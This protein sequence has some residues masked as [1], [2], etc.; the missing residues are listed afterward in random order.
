MAP[1]KNRY[2][3]P[4]VMPGVDTT[5]YFQNVKNTG[6][7]CTP[8]AYTGSYDYGNSFYSFEMGLAHVMVLNSYTNTSFGSAQYTWLED[9]LASVDTKVTPWIIAMFHSPWY[10]SNEV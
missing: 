6:F 10:N 7:D 2:K 8:S 4:E 1:Y 5:Q 9:D 3:M